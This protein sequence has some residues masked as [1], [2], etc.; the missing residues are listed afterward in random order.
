MISAVINLSKLKTRELHEYERPI[1][2]LALQ[3]AELNRDSK[4][5]KRPFQLEEFYLYNIKDDK[6]AIDPIYGAAALKLIEMGLFPAWALFVYKQLLERA[7][8][9]IPPL[10]LCYACDQAIVLAPQIEDGMCRGMLIAMESANMLSLN[11]TSP[12]GKSIRLRMP[13][14]KSKIIAEENCYIDIIG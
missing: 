14:I 5:R 6:D 9:S 2:V 11:L 8:E 3:N 4:K 1:S 13:Q 10:L 12:C 7:D